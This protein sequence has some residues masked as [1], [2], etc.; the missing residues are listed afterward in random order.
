MFN[1]KLDTLKNKYE[2]IF[3]IKLNEGFSSES[4]FIEIYCKSETL[5]S[6][7]TVSGA[8]QRNSDEHRER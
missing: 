7:Q 6:N 2:Y 4:S 3:Q 1:N 5:N 8:Q